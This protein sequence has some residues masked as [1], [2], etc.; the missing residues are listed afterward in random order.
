MSEALLVGT[1]ATGGDTGPEVIL[2][3][4][5]THGRRGLLARGA[6]A[7]PRR[8][9]LEVGHRPALEAGSEDG[10]RHSCRRTRG[11][12]YTRAERPTPCW[13]STRAYLQSSGAAG[14][15]LGPHPLPGVAPERAATAAATKR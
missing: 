7:V 4:G 11:T 5:G 10:A 2:T 1:A 14:P 3:R 13:L 8:A 15:V 12:P 6:P 9:A